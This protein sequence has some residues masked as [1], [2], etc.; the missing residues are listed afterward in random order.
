MGFF[1]VFAAVPFFGF[2]PNVP[3]CITCEWCLTQG[4]I[5]PDIGAFGAFSGFEGVTCS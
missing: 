1:M 4:L 2:S 5:T 3:L